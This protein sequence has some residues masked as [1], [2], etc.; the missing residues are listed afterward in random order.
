MPDLAPEDRRELTNVLYVPA[1]PLSAD[2]VCTK[3]RCSKCGTPLVRD[4]RSGKIG[5]CAACAIQCKRCGKMHIS[6]TRSGLCVPC[7]VEETLEFIADRRQWMAHLKI[8]YREEV[9]ESLIKAGLRKG[10]VSHEGTDSAVVGGGA[11][12]AGEHQGN[13][14][15]RA[16][17]KPARKPRPHHRG[18]AVRDLARF[19]R[20]HRPGIGKCALTPRTPDTPDRSRGDGLAPGTDGGVSPTES[21]SAPAHFPESRAR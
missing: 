10:K 15:A 19:G 16:E 3:G 7:E 12:A 4:G 6:V 2:V 18:V 21:Q 11:P 14:A 13:D 9:R 17:P 5:V 20:H 8:K 1:N